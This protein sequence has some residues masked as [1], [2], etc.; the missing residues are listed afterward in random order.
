MLPEDHALDT[1]GPDDAQNAGTMPLLG[2]FGSEADVDEFDVGYDGAAEGKRLAQQSGLLIGLVAVLAVG[3][4][5][6]MQVF[7]ASDAEAAPATEIASIEDFIRKSQRPELVSAADPQHPDR[8]QAMFS[9]AD[10]IVA[11]ISRTYPE[12]RVSVAE[13]AKNPFSRP[14]TEVLE[15][16]DVDQGEVRRAKQI[17][18]LQ[19]RLDRLELQSIMG[20]GDRSVAV[21]D[22]EFYRGGQSLEGFR[23]VSIQD[24]RV[25]LI[26]VGLELREGDPSFTLSIKSEISRVP[27]QRF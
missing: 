6:G 3:V 21:I 8:L 22:G 15:V 7:G 17:A 18:D 19:K 4:F 1:T 2:D 20:N 13:I 14:E 9:D 26:P 24:G 16:V 12:K 10:K 23:V 11:K 5:A 27:L 25:T